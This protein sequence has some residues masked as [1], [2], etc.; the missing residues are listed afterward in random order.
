MTTAH[1]RLMDGV[2]RHVL[3]VATELN[4]RVEVEILVCTALSE[5]ELNARLTENGVKNVALGLC[6]IRSVIGLY[7][8]Y[9]LLRCYRP[10]IVHFELPAV[11]FN[12]TVQIAKILGQKIKCVGT[13]H[14][15]PSAGRVGGYLTLFDYDALRAKILRFFQ[16]KMDG[17]IFVSQGVYDEYPRTE[18][19]EEIVYNPID[20]KNRM[21]RVRTSP[22][23]IGTACRMVDIK[24]PEAFTRIMLH[25]LERLP[26]VRAQV[27]G[28]GD[29]STMM[30][31]RK[32]IGSSRC[33]ERFSLLG[34]REDA[35]QLISNFSC[36]IMTSKCEGMPTALLEAMSQGVP[37]AFWKGRGG[38]KD[39]EAL[40][41]AKEPFAIVC[42]NGDYD[43]MVD[44][45]EKIL[46]DSVL[47][48]KMADRALRI[49]RSLFS[50][51]RTTDATIGHYRHV[52]A[53]R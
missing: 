42:E 30:A 23:V 37:I 39:L 35:K 46:Q 27:I 51:E 20:A 52:L 26:M 19:V 47:A 10:D 5:G 18:A 38:L 1:S 40:N 13:V 17:L 43:H 15:V 2:N 49:C 11:F 7:R 34:Y 24:Q 45:I 41:N 21:S 29:P 50:L 44:G 14:G 3:A 12:V 16:N 22:S 48:D 32:V 31:L 33:A 4:K 25:V 28:D 9:K 36:F 6:S 53:T 8:F